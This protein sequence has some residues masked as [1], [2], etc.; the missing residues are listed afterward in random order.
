MG[1]GSDD[2]NDEEGDDDELDG[3]GDGDSDT[4][5]DEDNLPWISTIRDWSNCVLVAAQPL[6]YCTL[7]KHE[8]DDNN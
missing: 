2:S 8:D 4:V 7:L 1:D 6:V 3:D 5:A